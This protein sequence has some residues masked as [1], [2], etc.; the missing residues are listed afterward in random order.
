MPV[1]GRENGEILPKRLFLTIFKSMDSLPRAPRSSNMWIYVAKEDTLMQSKERTEQ[2][3][4]SGEASNVD[5]KFTHWSEKSVWLDIAISRPVIL[6]SVASYFPMTDF[7]TPRPIQAPL[8]REMENVRT[9]W[10]EVKVSSGIL[11][12]VKNEYKFSL[13]K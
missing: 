6:L 11:T 13:P 1:K 10:K 9:K 8:K 2:V 3:G 7:C 12:L 4:R 5:R